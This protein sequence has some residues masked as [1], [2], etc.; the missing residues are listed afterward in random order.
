MT[1]E[2]EI[3]VSL[4]EERPSIYDFNDKDHSNRI[5]QDRLWEE[6]NKEMNVDGNFNNNINYNISLIII[7]YLLYL[8]Y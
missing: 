3:L 8:L 2:G 4:V 7:I 5:V 1:C 6:I